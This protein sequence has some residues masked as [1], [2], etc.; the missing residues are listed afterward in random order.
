MTTLSK[1]PVADAF[2]NCLANADYYATPFDHW[3]IADA[4]P[5]ADV[6]AIEALPFAPPRDMVFNGKREANNSVRV[7]FNRENQEQFEVC[8]RVADGFN[9]ARV[10]HAIEETTGANLTDTHLRIE[11]CQDVE[12]S[13]SRR[14]S[15]C[16]QEI[17]DAGVSLQGPAPQDGRYG[18]SRGAARLQLYGFDAYGRNLGLIFIPGKNTW[19]AVG[20]TAAERLDPHLDHRQLRHIGLARGVGAVVADRRARQFSAPRVSR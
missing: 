12:G 2:L 15:T 9:D 19:H 14:T 17:L 1:N 10:R 20:Q 8:R 3:L 5:E 16:G 13:G 11:Y 7:F 18:P 4:L 6:T